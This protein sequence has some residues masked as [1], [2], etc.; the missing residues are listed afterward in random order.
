MAQC[1]A[2]RAAALPSGA[3]FIRRA[4]RG[5]MEEY[6]CDAGSSPPFRFSDDEDDGAPPSDEDEVSHASQHDA[7]APAST[8]AGGRPAN[9]GGRA[10][11][12]RQL[13]SGAGSTRQGGQ[14]PGPGA[15]AQGVAARVATAPS[16]DYNTG[17]A[18]WSCLLKTGMRPGWARGYVLA[19]CRLSPPLKLGLTNA[20]PGWT[21]EN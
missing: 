19:F 18:A 7:P 17:A 8:S 11:D 14:F 9:A 12:V 16:I 21:I 1:A 20:S 2:R 5:G 13:P 4:L 3:P 10:S 15:S 6:A